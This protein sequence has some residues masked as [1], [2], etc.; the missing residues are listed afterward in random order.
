MTGRLLTTNSLSV[1][2]MNL[3]VKEFNFT[4]ENP[5][6]FRVSLWGDL[7]TVSRNY[8]AFRFFTAL[9]HLA[10]SVAWAV[11]FDTG[12]QISFL[13]CLPVSSVPLLIH[14]NLNLSLTFKAFIN[15]RHGEKLR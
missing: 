2:K 8:L 5:E 6:L 14:L 10:A 9:F 3:C 13:F 7:K 11:L 4:H 15:Q 12:H 1:A